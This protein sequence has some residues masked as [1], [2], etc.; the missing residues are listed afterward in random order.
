MVNIVIYKR[1]ELHMGFK[2]Y[3]HAGMADAGQDIVCAAISILTINTMNAIDKFTQDKYDQLVDGKNACIDF[4][5]TSVP[6][7]E[8]NLLL[9]TMVLGIRAIFEDYERYIN[10]S[11]KEV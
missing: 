1:G 9:R 3:G 4:K 11:F 10:L 7:E 6:T 8:A 5:L 2:S